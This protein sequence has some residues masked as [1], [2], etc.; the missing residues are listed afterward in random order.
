MNLAI[1]SS[2]EQAVLGLLES[3]LHSHLNLLET[4]NACNHF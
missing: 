1:Y 3:F 2:Y 4:S